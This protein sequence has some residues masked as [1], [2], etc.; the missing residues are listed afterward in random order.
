MRRA[1][2]SILGLV[3]MLAM[4][5][6]QTNAD[7][8]ITIDFETDLS[9]TPVGLDDGPTID[10]ISALTPLTADVAEDPAGLLEI[11]V[12]AASSFDP[13]NSNVNASGSGFGI[14]SPTPDGGSENASRFDVDAAETLTFAFNQDVNFI[15]VEFTNLSGTEEFTFGSVTGINDV[16]TDTADVFTFADGGIFLAAGTG[17]TLQASGPAGSSVGLEAITLEIL[18]VPEPTSATLIAFGLSGLCMVRRRR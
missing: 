17:I 7:I 12:I 9:M 1:F 16:N 10:T 13:A 5:M 11:S 6:V 3:A 18:A 14:N 8:V 15:N 4:P 2:L